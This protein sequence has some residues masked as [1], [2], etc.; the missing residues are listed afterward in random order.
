[1]LSAHKPRSR[2]A[3]QHRAI[4]LA[5]VFLLFD[6]VGDVQK[7]V[8][9]QPYIHKGG[10]HAGKHAGYAAV[11]NRAGECVF[12]FALVMDLNEL[13]IFDN[14]EPRLVRRS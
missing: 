12:V 1:L 7:R 4:K 11:I 3:G 9:V 10:L 6:E 13:L 5:R 14:C 8:P 2:L